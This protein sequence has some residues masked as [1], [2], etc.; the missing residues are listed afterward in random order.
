MKSLRIAR[1]LL[2][3][4]RWLWLLLVLWPWGMVAML[5]V[6]GLQPAPEDLEALF[7]QQ[8]IYGLALVAF[9]GGALLGNEQRS[10]RIVLVLS[11][12][13]SRR[14]YLGALW[15]AAFLPLLLYAIDLALTGAVLGSSALMLG[16]TLTALLLLGLTA[17]S[18]AVLASLALPGV[19]AGVLTL[20]VLSSPLLLPPGWQ[21]AQTRLLQILLGGPATEHVRLVFGAGLLEA[22]LLSAAILEAAVRIFERRDL[23]LKSE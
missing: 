1:Q 15:L 7:E 6:G 19:I 10:R 11:R 4:N 22:L 2:W 16:Q 20:G 13:V 21:T 12:A 5:L 9:V 18:L 23:R 14:Q 3:A 8:S 17:A